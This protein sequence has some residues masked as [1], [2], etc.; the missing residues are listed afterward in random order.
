M[1]RP[2]TIESYIYLVQSALDDVIDLKMSAEYDMED[3][4][5]ALSFVGG[6]EVE[7]RKLLSNLNS[8]SYKFV[9]EDLELMSIVNAQNNLMLPFKSLFI[10]INDTHRKGLEQ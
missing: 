3:M 6:L 9:N 1:K 5:E 10:R 7:L 8:G 2:N 4:G